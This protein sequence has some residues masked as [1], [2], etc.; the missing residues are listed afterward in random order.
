MNVTIRQ[1]RAFIA[2][3]RE[4]SFTSAA[5]KMSMTQ[6][7]LTT[8]VKTLEN[9]LGH[10]L[11]ERKGR[12]IRLTPA[13]EL[14][15]DTATTLLQEIDTS[16]HTAQLNADRLSGYI[17]LSAPTWFL[18]LIVSTALSNLIPGNPSLSLNLYS[19]T[20]HKATQGILADEL[21]FA[22]CSQPDQ[23]SALSVTKLL[24][25]RMGVLTVEKQPPVSHINWKNLNGQR[26]IALSNETGIN[27]VLNMNGIMSH[28]TPRPVCQV[29]NTRTISTLVRL[30]LGYSI[31][32]A[33]TARLLVEDGLSFVPLSFPSVVRELYLVKRRCRRLS[34]QSALFLRELL[35]LIERICDLPDV[36]I[37]ITRADLDEF[38]LS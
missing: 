22:I 15:L 11:L 10:I 18:Q 29:A 9:Q 17:S 6:P 27:K 25:D 1:M 4:L 14:F 16:L 2:V 8:S 3:A 38:I 12:T 13:G 5:R 33:M 24:E 36:S 31:V 21:D 37:K 35:P 23:N 19:H 30:G 28:G 34:A 26:Y 7:A 32:P 20:T